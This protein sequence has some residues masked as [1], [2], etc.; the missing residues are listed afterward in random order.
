MKLY[1]AQLEVTIDVLDY[2]GEAEEQTPEDLVKAMLNTSSPKT[3]GY[4]ICTLGKLT[5][6]LH[7]DKVT[8]ESTSCEQC[9]HKV[10]VTEVTKP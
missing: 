6:T 4:A 1:K 10:P 7:I 8:F 9:G 2:G 5:S 3:N